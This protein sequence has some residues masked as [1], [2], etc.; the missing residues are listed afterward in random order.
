MVHCVIELILLRM[1][2]EEYS[3][4]SQT[5]TAGFS[6]VWNDNFA[7]D[8]SLNRSLFGI[9]WGNSS[10]FSFSNGAFTLSSKASEGWSN[11]GFMRPD[12]NAGS[13]DGYGRYTA[14]ASLDAG[15][16]AGICIDLWPSNNQWPGAEIDLLETS[17][18]S[19]STGIA[20]VH[21]A[22]SGNSNQYDY[23]TFSVNLTQKNTYS[24]D[25]ERG[26]ITYSVN[27]HVIFKNTAHVPLDA[28]D[29]G[30]NESF[31]AEVVNAGSGAVSSAVNLHLYSMSYAK[32]TSSS[33][34]SVSAD[35]K[36][37]TTTASASPTMQFL[38]AS[39]TTQ[40]LASGESLTVSGSG[41]TI[42]L[43]ASGSITLGGSVL[44]NTLDLRSVMATS[45][46]DHQAADLA[47]YVSSSTTNGGADLRLSVHNTGG[48]SLLTAD[49]VG[50]G[51][52]T[53]AVVEQHSLFG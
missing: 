52:T 19:R 32:P 30:V 45:G 8:S 4:L 34:A 38:T 48:A 53:L 7:T 1:D 17:G 27:G 40:V 26:S 51:H 41:N 20:T 25:W 10:D 3:C 46:W 42:A 35:T 43:P 44:S 2:A 11:A 14:V 29:G 49:L 13:G 50:Q 18:S 9:Q 15:Q 6:T 16:G 12:F 36:T 23:H 21:W 47:K 31:G 33:A 22:G 37:T 28:A 39:N 5:Q 24:V